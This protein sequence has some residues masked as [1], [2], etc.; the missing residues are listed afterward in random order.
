[1]DTQLGGPGK[2]S[3]LPQESLADQASCSRECPREGSRAEAWEG[4]RGLWLAH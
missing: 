2:L 1:M 3:A 4:P